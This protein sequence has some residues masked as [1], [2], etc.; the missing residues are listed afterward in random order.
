MAIQDLG[1][2]LLSDRREKLASRERQ[3]EEQQKKIERRQMFK[4]AGSLIGS[5]F[6]TNAQKKALS[7][8]QQEPIMAARA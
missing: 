5:A 4:T 3:R 7:F 8:L 2:S 1:E 6:Q